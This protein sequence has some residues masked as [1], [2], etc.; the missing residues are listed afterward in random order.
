MNGMLARTRPAEASVSTIMRSSGR[1]LS[2]GRRTTAAVDVDAQPV[3]G[4]SW[5]TTGHGRHSAS[6]AAAKRDG[7]AGSSGPCR[8]IRTRL[9]SRRLVS[10]R[11]KWS[12]TAN[13]T[14]PAPLYGKL[15]RPSHGQGWASRGAEAEQWSPDDALASACM[16][17][18]GR[19]G[20]LGGAGVLIAPDLV[21]S[22][23]QA[24]RM[25][26]ERSRRWLSRSEPW[27]PS[28]SRRR[29]PPGREVGKSPAGSTWHAIGAAVLWPSRSPGTGRGRPAVRSVLRKIRVR[30]PVGRPRTRPDAVAGD[31]AYS[32]RANSAHLRKTTSR[33]TGR[34]TGR[35]RAAG[36]AARLP[37]RR[38][39]SRPQHR[40]TN[41]QR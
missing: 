33:R 29:I 17:N 2:G 19:N 1:V 3:A 11:A 20:R 6:C 5:Y 30:G 27:S 25:R 12:G 26:C 34:P 41:D 13:G 31:K 21:P 10:A 36:R 18:K 4:E 24:Y 7:P 23:T 22:C 28:N 14:Q 15:I 16:R 32:P 38:S 9:H 39:L 40:R 8:R 35:G 37:R